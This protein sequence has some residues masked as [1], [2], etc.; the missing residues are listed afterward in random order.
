MARIALVLMSL[1]MLFV[2][3]VYAADLATPS[4]DD[5]DYPEEEAPSAKEVELGKTLFFDPRL[6]L[7]MK[8]SCGTCHNP[9]LGFGDGLATGLGTMGGG[10]GRNTPHVYN[11]AWNVTFFWD[12]RAG[13][14]E[15][16]AL[17][18]IEAA[19]EMNMPLEKLIPRLQAVKYYQDMFKA[20]YGDGI[21]KANIGKA[22]AS[23]ERTL[24]AVNTPFDKYLAGNKTAMGPEAIRGLELFK[25]K[26]NCTGCHDGPNFTDNSYHNI[27][28]KGD[29]KGR[30]G[31]AGGKEMRGAFKTPGLRNVIFT[32]PYMHDGSEGSL[33]SVVQF[34][35]RGGDQDKNKSNLIKKLNLSDQEVS[36]LVAFLGALTDPIQ[37]ERP[38]IP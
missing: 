14:L 20:V 25:G 24:N 22:I 18:P 5:I 38:K 31:I 16:Q 17:G 8:Q 28:V 27:G 30:E 10:L 35:N 11:L 32:A 23:F 29:D 34:Y 3:K 6:S 21:N 13:S 2:G 1:L 9:D 15:E 33:E 26:A 12:G 36:D 4:M 37:V 7:N 19:G